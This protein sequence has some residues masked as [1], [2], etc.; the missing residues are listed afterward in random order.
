MTR[1]YFCLCLFVT[2][3]VD[4]SAQLTSEPQ[5]TGE[6]YRLG[7]VCFSSVRDNES[8]AH[9]IHAL[10]S[11]IEQ[12]VQA[13]SKVARALRTYTVQSTSYLIPEFCQT[14]GV[15]VMVGAWIGPDRWQNDAQLERLIQLAGK[16]NPRIKSVIIGNEVLHRGDCD[17]AQLIAYVQLAKQNLDLPVAV[18]DTWK[19][20]IEHPR[21]AAAVDI[22]G[23]QIYPYW[24]GLSIDTA[25]E[26]TLQRV[27][28]V[29]SA[30]PDKRIV[31]TEFGWP[32]EGDALGQAEAT[33]RNAARYIREVVP[34]LDQS[35][36][37]Y[38]YFALWD[39][40]WKVGP[41]GG[42]GAH[43]GLFHSDGSI[44]PAFRNVLPTSVHGGTQ[45]PPRAVTFELPADD[46]RNA[47]LERV[48]LGNA[49]KRRPALSQR[50]A[51][52]ENSL[53]PVAQT[54]YGGLRPLR[55]GEPSRP[56]SKQQP[57][58]RPDAGP[59]P[60]DGA[61]HAANHHSLVSTFPTQV[62]IVGDQSETRS[63]SRN[64][65]KIK[66]FR[67]QPLDGVCLSLFRDNESPHFGITPLISEVRADVGYAGKL[68]RT[69]RTYSVTDS[70]AFVPQIASE[71]GLDCYPGAA[72]GK[73]PWLNELELEMLI[74]VGQ[75]PDSNIKALIVGN[76][77]LHRGDFSVEQY[78][79]YIR[80]VKQQV[81]APVAIAELL[82]SWMEHP[83]L[84]AEVDLLGVQIYPYWGGLSIEAAA[85]NTIES[86]KRL[87]DQ[88]PGKRVV[89]TEFGWPTAGGKIGAADANPE[90]AATY[91]RE[92]I[93]LL[94]AHKIEYLYF[95]MT[96]ESWKQ[97][98]EG[99]PGA[100]WGLLGANGTVKPCFENLIPTA[101]SGGLKRSARKLSFDR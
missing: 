97:Q 50:S 99:G 16:E 55:T 82:H 37:E 18:A 93:P 54:T 48:A 4:A 90:N 47:S 25:A 81:D 69:V 28:D 65:A 1:I 5:L 52:L 100:H 57:A 75:D 6:P 53:E 96:D 76:E 15:D 101:A 74:R 91:F 21:L 70:F 36:V 19:S 46:H 83:E 67:S 88:Y 87:Q 22:C 89:L 58:D 73:Y 31:L 64:T 34:L 38:F 9:Q 43:W 95:A 71:F 80:R 59:T 61:Y 10:P 49:G 30:Y 84:V 26:Y 41:E 3:V 45:R 23:V 12:D 68:A 13:A 32:T 27:R 40:K 17:E 14:Y 7:G 85:Q 77:V 11:A 79:Q 44:K 20:W 62:A 51:G 66:R 92:V 42:V 33:P 86:V 2:F 35:G 72:M 78:I 94:E 63:Q 98:D 60:R 29:Q 24:E 56:N 8:P 39:E